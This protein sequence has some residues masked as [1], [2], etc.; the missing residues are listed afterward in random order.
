MVSIRG[1]FLDFYRVSLGV[2]H[3]FTDRV[4][5]LICHKVPPGIS[6]RVT[7]EICSSRFLEIISRLHLGNSF[8]GFLWFYSRVSSAFLTSISLD[9]PL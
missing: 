9:G 1:F 6:Q 5:P 2:F 3:G 7:S 8:N 4:L